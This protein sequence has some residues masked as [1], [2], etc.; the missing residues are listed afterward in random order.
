MRKWTLEHLILSVDWFAE[1][2]LFFVTFKML[3]FNVIKKLNQN[4]LI[5]KYSLNFYFI[6]FYLNILFLYFLFKILIYKIDHLII[7]ILSPFDNQLIIEVVN[8]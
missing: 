5:N 6:Y 8:C 1:Q 4:I 3:F 7:Y 2:L